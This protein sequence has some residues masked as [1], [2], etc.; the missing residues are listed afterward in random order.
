MNFQFNEAKRLVLNDIFVAEKD[1]AKTS[2]YRL[3]VDNQHL[4]MFKS[5]GI[6]ISTG[7]GSSGWLFSARRI[8]KSDVK[9]ILDF[10][11]KGEGKSEEITK[12]FAVTQTG[13]T[14]F[15][16]DE[17]R[18]YYFVRETYAHK[19]TRG[20]SI[21]KEGYASNLSFVSELED[22]KVYIDGNFRIDIGIGDR[23]YVDSKPEY[24]LKCIKFDI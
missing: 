2:I 15:N 23:F 18:M 21:H 20:F 5:S 8:V 6:I 3:I 1:T 17:E 14:L 16:A 9:S 10:L 12:Q 11:G 19:R 24:R 13:K 22:G 7:T 4:G